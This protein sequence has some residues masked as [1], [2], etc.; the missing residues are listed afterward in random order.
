MHSPHDE[1]DLLQGISIYLETSPVYT[2]TVILIIKMLYDLDI[3]DEDAIF[4]YYEIES[5]C[6]MRELMK[7]FYEWL[8]DADEEESESESDSGDESGLESGL[9]S[10]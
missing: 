5:E 2:K 7:P 3:I 9:E 8:K 10:V 4:S 6:K 1:L